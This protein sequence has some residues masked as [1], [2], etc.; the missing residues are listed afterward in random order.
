MT[1]NKLALA[2]ALF[3]CTGAAFAQSGTDWTGFYVGANAGQANGTSDVT[4]TTVFSSTG[5]FATTSVPAINSAG[6]G[7]VSPDG[8]T[9]GVAAGYNWQHNAVVFGFEGDWNSLSADDSR[10]DGAA[11]PCCT[12]T[13]FTVSE[14]TKVS[15]FATLRGRLGYASGN[16]LF[17]VTAGYAQ[18]KIKIDDEFN[19]TFATAHESFS[20]SKTKHDW[21]YGLGYEYGFAGN[22]SFKAE[23]LYADFGKVTGT[24]TNLTAFTPSIAFPTNVFTHTADLRLNVFRVGINYRF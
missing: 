19:D 6:D 7:S 21:T 4:T 13:S 8:F 23:Y 24:S 9:G 20:D 12:T 11:Y 16:S 17:Y 3:G 1:F 22:W 5:Y 15:D 2:L 18:A 14:K 10:T